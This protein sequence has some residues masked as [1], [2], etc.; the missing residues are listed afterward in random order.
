MNLIDILI[1]GIAACLI[2]F[3]KHPIWRKYLTLAVSTL[4]LFLFQ[5]ASP[6]RHL[7]FW[8][9]LGTLTITTLSWF[10]LKFFKEVNLK[11][12]FGTL[13][14]PLLIVLIFLA[15]RYLGF[16]PKIDIIQIPQFYGPI[17]FILVLSLIAFLSLRLK[18]SRSTLVIS[19]LII[20]LIFLKSPLLSNYLSLVLRGFNGQ[21][22]ANASALDFR[23]LGFS[24]IAFRIIH[25]ARERQLGKLQG[26]SLADYINYVIFFPSLAAG[27]IDK[28]DHFTREV[29]QP[30][31]LTWDAFGDGANRIIL[32]IFKKFILADGLALM[33]INNSNSL[34]IHSTGWLWF[35]LYAY[36]LQIYFDFSGYTDVAIGLALWMGIR[37][38]ENF[39]TPYLKPNLTQFWNNWHM[40]L[41]QWFR[42]YVF[43]PLTRFLRSRGKPLPVYLVILT[44]QLVTMVLIGLWHG[45]TINFILWGAWHGIGLFIHNRWS[46]RIN[47][48][49]QDWA[50][51][52]TRQ[53]LLAISSGFLTFNYVTLG[54]TFFTLNN[55]QLTWQVLQRL[56][57]VG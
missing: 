3:I 45:I 5:P 16:I 51:T 53:R 42:S 55:P 41:T 27:P 13:V 35:A 29:N 7:V 44:T 25:A 8:L 36:S 23:W 30:F 19:I 4:F 46:N 54:W 37:L 38:P 34:Q 57:G 6:I 1:L 28:L 31:T 11:Q 17:I 2:G 9:P 56:V 15:D 39:S 26:I 20:I 24:Y 21:A 48:R 12:T 14:I 50:T 49:L 10:F 33:A 47:P 22:T 52:A 40:T 18:Q 32:G 43:N